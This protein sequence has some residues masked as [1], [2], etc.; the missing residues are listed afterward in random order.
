MSKLAPVVYFRRSLVDE[1]ER[2]AASKYF[3]VVDRRT[4]IPPNSLVIPRYSALPFN[5]ELEEDVKSLGSRLINTHQQHLYVADLKNWYEDLSA[6]TPRTWFSL[7]DIPDNGPFVLKGATN[8]KKSLWSTHCFASTK[9]E[10]IETYLRLKGDGFVG[11]QDI[12]IRQYVPLR[13]LCDSITFSGPPIS[14]E[15]RF[16]VLDGKVIASGFYWSEYLDDLEI[17]VNPSFVPKEFLDNVIEKVMPNIP[18]FVVDI[19]RTSDNNWVV[20]ELN[21]GQ[22]SGLSA[23]APEEFYRNLY[24]ALGGC[25][26]Y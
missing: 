22:Q 2:A 5:T 9:K 16:F 10:A 15:Y 11:Y 12:Y 14:E 24:L 4:A 6:V 21:D 3:S 7:S 19:A 18:F 23:I 26:T 13:K 8:S 20:I 1:E 25:D 17:E